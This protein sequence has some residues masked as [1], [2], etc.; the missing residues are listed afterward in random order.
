[1]Q[2]LDIKNKYEKN[3]LQELNETDSSP[4]TELEWDNPKTIINDVAYDDVEQE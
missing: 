2:N 4:D 3:I 1:L